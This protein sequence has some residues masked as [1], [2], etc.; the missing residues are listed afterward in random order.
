MRQ[1][2]R[3]SEI[4]ASSDD[5]PS[6]EEIRLQAVDDDCEAAVAFIGPSAGGWL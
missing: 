4:D 2:A 3:D 1:H 6:E 5:S